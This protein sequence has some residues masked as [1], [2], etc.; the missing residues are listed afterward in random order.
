[1]PFTNLKNH[2]FKEVPDTSALFF[3]FRRFVDQIVT[4]APVVLLEFFQ[5]TGIPLFIPPV[6]REQLC[7]A[8]RYA[9]CQDASRNSSHF[10]HGL[11][12]CDIQ[13]ES[14]CRKAERGCLPQHRVERITA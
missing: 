2:R 1:M 14:L 4:Q 9:K 3:S 6:P 8:K 11:I 13:E 12:S 5:P 10:I 7:C